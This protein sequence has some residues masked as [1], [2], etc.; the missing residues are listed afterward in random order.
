MQVLQGSLSLSSTS[1]VKYIDSSLRLEAMKLPP[2]TAVPKKRMTL[3]RMRKAQ[4]LKSAIE[5]GEED[6]SKE[7]DWP[8]LTL[9]HLVKVVQ[10]AQ[11]LV[12]GASPP[13]SRLPQ[14]RRLPLRARVRAKGKEPEPEP[15][16]EGP[17]P[18][19]PQEWVETTTTNSVVHGS[20]STAH[21]TLISERDAALQAFSASPTTTLW[22]CAPATP[23][24]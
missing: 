21:R 17:P 14:R 20:V 8:A 9:E 23:P 13:P 4:R 2:D 22:R 5:A 12:E 19:L 6:R 18:L 7:R 3:K 24:C 15:E 16:S 1:L 11:D 10:D